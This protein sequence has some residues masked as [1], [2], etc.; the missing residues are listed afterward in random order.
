[1]TT[2]L[3]S[4][5]QLSDCVVEALWDRVQLPGPSNGTS[6]DSKPGPR[7][8]ESSPLI[9][10]AFDIGTIGRT[11]V[12]VTLENPFA[13]DHVVAVVFAVTI[14]GVAVV[15]RVVE[16]V[17]VVVLGTR[18]VTGDVEEGGG[19]ET[20]GTCG[21]DDALRVKTRTSNKTGLDHIR[22]WALFSEKGERGMV[23]E[24]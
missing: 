23:F 20:T 2:G 1:L 21:G 16:I 7:V 9:A 19:D 3:T 11:V 22:R 13:A 8:P 5:P 6:T 18:V 10:F 17:V 4:A 14:T 15:E 12:A 24:G